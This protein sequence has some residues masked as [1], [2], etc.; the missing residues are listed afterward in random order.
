MPSVSQDP[1]TDIR[2]QITEAIGAHGAWKTRLKAAALAGS[3]TIDPA[4]AADGHGCRFGQWLDGYLR[5]HPN[6]RNAR[7]IG[8]LHQQ[9]HRC[10]GNVAL[11]IRDGRGTEALTEI[12]SGKLKVITNNLVSEMMAWRRNF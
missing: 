4:R 9:F 12:E 1:N 8:D 10:A 5:A 3:T 7:R 2:T 6:D 11:S